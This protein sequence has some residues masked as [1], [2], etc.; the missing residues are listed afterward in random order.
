MREYSEYRDVGL[1][2]VEKVPGHW[3]VLPN[4]AV[5]EERIDKGHDHLP[6]LSVTIA[7]GVITQEEFL[8][9]ST[10]KDSSNEDKSSY[11]RVLCGDLAYNKMRMWQGAVGFSKYDGIASP[12]Y[13]ILK[14]RKS[15]IPEY[16]HYLLRIPAYINYSYRYSYGIC[17]DQ[18]SLR[19]T[20]FKRM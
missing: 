13:I 12:A 4:F 6:L 11:K 1:P 7:Q 5:F 16:Y 2:W 18:L 20:D 3:E 9:N 19:Y 14:P 10:K 15:I 17:D 8:K